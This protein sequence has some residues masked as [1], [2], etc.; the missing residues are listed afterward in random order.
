MSQWTKSILVWGLRGVLVL[1]AIVGGIHAVNVLGGPSKPTNIEADTVASDWNEAVH[2]LNI[3]PIYPP[4]EDVYV[5][6]I[7]ATIS[8]GEPDFL[9]RSIKLWHLNLNGAIERSYRDLP[10]FPTTGPVPE[11]DG[12]VWQQETADFLFSPAQRKSLSLVAF[13]SFVVRHARGASAGGSFAG[14][15]ALFGASRDSEERE[16]L[17]FPRTETYGVNATEATAALISFCEAERSKPICADTGVRQMLSM[18]VGEAIWKPALDAQGKSTGRYAINVELVLVSQVYLTRSIV[19]VHS[20]DSRQ[21]QI[22]QVVQKVQELGDQPAP[23]PSAAG[24]QGG[25]AAKPFT[26]DQTQKLKELQDS[27]KDLNRS[28]AGA[29]VTATATDGTSIALN[30]VFPRPIAIGVKTVRR[31]PTPS[32]TGAGA[33][34]QRGRSK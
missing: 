6:D 32:Q 13:P 27:L 33:G 11:K 1:L 28:V 25:E 22:A 9:G 34:Q 19:R 14:W 2:K 21:A 18:L 30:Q 24:S 3:E 5:G 16:E 26:R 4:Q 31:I 17:R 10:V 20:V 7:Y 15:K 23:A 29:T 12:E 8:S